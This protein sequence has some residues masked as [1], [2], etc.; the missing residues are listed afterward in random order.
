MKR[1]LPAIFYN[2][3]TL[4]GMTWALVMF[5]LTLVLIAMDLFGGFSNNYSGII[6][7]LILPSL[8]FFGV[9]IGIIGLIRARKKQKKGEIPEELPIIDLNKP[10]HR[11]TVTSVAVGGLVLMALS[12]FGSYKGYEYTETVQFCGTT[13]HSLMEPEYTAYQASPHARVTCAGCHIGSGVDYYVKSKLSGSYQ[14]YSTIFNKYER[15]IK[16]PIANLR[17]AKETCEQCH[18]PKKFFAEKLL[19]HNYYL[20]DEQN[21]EVSLS[22]LIK[23]GGGDGNEAQGIHAHMYLNSTMTY[24]ASDYERQNIPYV[25]M[26]DKSGKVTI[27]R[28]PEAKFTDADIAK[29]ERRTVDCID[30]HNRPTHIFNPPDRSVNKALSSGAIDKTIP[31]IK[32]KAVEV[33]NA[34]YKTPVEATDK[35]ATELKKYYQETYADFMKEGAGKLD[36]AIKAVQ[37]IYRQNFFPIMKTDWRSHYD[38]L[39]HMH[40]NGCFRCHND[41]LKTDTGKVISKNCNTCHKFV[42]IKKDGVVKSDYKGLAFDHPMDVGDEWKTTPCKDCHGPEQPEEPEPAAK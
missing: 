37:G 22:M 41:R 36:A 14:V 2:P 6:T 5:I 31:E 15:P 21:S 10:K 28:D 8:M 13:C 30:C 11:A 23:I 29:G 4:F 3:I 1:R 7:Y 39:D 20:S 34:S 42:E 12:G 26:K 25:E 40:N 18:W 9:F 19:T 38:N 24:I 16:T 17:P 27:Y 35:I 32:S 33:L